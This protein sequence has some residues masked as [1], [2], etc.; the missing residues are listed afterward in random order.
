MIDA[1]KIMK[2]GCTF[3]RR[4]IPFEGEK[5]LRMLSVLSHG[6]YGLKYIY[7]CEYCSEIEKYYLE[8]E[9]E[10]IKKFHKDIPYQY[11]SR[12][13]LHKATIEKLPVECLKCHI[14]SPHGENWKLISADDISFSIICPQCAIDLE[15][16]Q[17]E[18]NEKFIEE[19]AK[20]EE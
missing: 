16:K 3:C 4:E 18:F 11:P 8:Q 2:D 19:Y 9:G 17:K 13:D 12:K 20:L 6:A 5:P 14:T 7:I 1:S 10:L 15:Q